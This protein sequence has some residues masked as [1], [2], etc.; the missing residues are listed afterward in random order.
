MGGSFSTLMAKYG[1]TQTKIYRAVVT[2]V[3]PVKHSCSVKG[4]MKGGQWSG[5]EIMPMYQTTNGSGSF[6]L[7]EVGAVV[8][9]CSPADRDRPFIVGFSPSPSAENQGSDD[10]DPLD[11]RM[12]RPVINPGDY[13][14]ASQDT[15][16][17]V[18]RKSGHIELGSGQSAKRA[19]IPLTNIIRDT[20]ESYLMAAAG[21]EFSW[22]ARREDESRGSDVTPVEY[23]LRIKEFV[24]EEP[25]L[26][27]AFG[28]IEGED[29]FFVPPN[30]EIG[31]IIGRFILETPDGARNFAAYLDREGN[32]MYHTTGDISENVEGS[33]SIY[34]RNT[35]QERVVGLR[36]SFVGVRKQQVGTDDVLEVGRSRRMTVEGDVIDVIGG[37]YTKTANGP[38]VESLGAVTQVI[39]GQFQRDVV[40][41]MNESVAGGKQVTVM[42][43]YDEIVAMTKTLIVGNAI[44]GG[45]AFK[46]V[47]ANGN[48]DLAAPIGQIQISGTAAVV[49]GLT[50]VQV[51]SILAAQPAV[52]GLEWTALWTALLLWMD[53]HVHGCTAPG[54]PST[55]PLI[56]STPTLGPL[57]TNSLS[58]KVLLE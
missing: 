47:A 34:V 38:T 48:I 46:V 54:A 52:L 51:G 25:I 44:P 15:A 39:A 6:Y 4:E 14:L 36:S 17:I 57:Q 56:P 22:A 19:Y 31:R 50:V 5:V 24:E 32:V 30:G 2:S 43:N 9:A 21:G 37:S 13:M 12:N 40:G 7:P 20:F 45:D 49:G 10:E 58:T 29:D 18:L 3:D 41:N 23:R 16:F 42:E 26:D 55:P 53:T 28:R 1:L 27:I 8:W 35:F 11:S 33:R